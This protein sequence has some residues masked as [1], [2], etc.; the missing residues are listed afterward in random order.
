MSPMSPVSR[1]TVPHLRCG[2]CDETIEKGE[3]TR[4]VDDE[5]CHADCAHEHEDG[6]R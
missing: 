4:D 3:P 2:L 5:R 1:R 6:E